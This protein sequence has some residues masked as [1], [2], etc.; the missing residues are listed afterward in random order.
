M[1]PTSDAKVFYIF[2][3]NGVFNAKKSF[4][5]QQSVMLVTDVGDSLSW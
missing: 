1:K 5:R 4:V 3:Q 2:E